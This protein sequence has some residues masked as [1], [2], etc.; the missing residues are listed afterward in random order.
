MA[1][2]R[3]LSTGAIKHLVQFPPANL[4]GGNSIL[5]RRIGPSVFEPSKSQIL[6]WV[7]SNAQKYLAPD[8]SG[9]NLAP[10]AKRAR[11]SRKKALRRARRMASFEKQSGRLDAVRIFYGRAPGLGSQFAAASHLTTRWRRCPWE[12]TSARRRTR[13]TRSF[14]FLSGIPVVGGIKSRSPH[15][16]ALP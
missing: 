3:E 5:I 12:R 15:L 11:N 1:A 6:D 10:C 8:R 16:V 2:S 7:T 9:L 13:I 14:D 4:Q